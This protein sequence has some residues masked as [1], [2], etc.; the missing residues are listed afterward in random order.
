MNAST[1]KSNDIIRYPMVLL[2]YAEAS[3]MAAGA[4]TTAGYKAINLVRARAGL[5]DL[6]PGLSGTAFRDS[7]VY[8]RAYE[9]AGE[10]G[11]RWFDIVRLQILP[12]VIAG[13]GTGL[14]GNNW[15]PRE[16]PIPEAT[17]AD[18]SHCY[19]APIPQSDMLL[20]PTWIQNPGY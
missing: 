2:D 9:F 17:I 19:L 16:N 7:V 11:M 5:P 3:A 4:P 15:Q 13:R 12:Q 6:T 10:N 18:P 20:N 1:N 8:E 14:F